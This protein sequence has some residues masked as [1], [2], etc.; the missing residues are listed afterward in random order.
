MAWEVRFFA[1][2]RAFGNAPHG[3]PCVFEAEA[4][5]LTHARI[6]L[7]RAPEARVEVFDRDVGRRA[8]YRL[9]GARMVALAEPP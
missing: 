8:V 3:G 2:R 7:H 6:L 5:A 1:D 9:R 4:D